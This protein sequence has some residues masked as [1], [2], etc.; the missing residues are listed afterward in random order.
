[1]RPP[2]PPPHRQVVA[3][4]SSPSLTSFS[5]IPSPRQRLLRPPPSLSG[6]TGAGP[7]Q[8]CPTPS[9]WLFPHRCQKG[10][11]GPCSAP[12][13][14]VELIASRPLMA[15]PRGVPHGAPGN[16]AAHRSRTC[17]RAVPVCPIRDVATSRAREVSLT[18]EQPSADPAAT[19]SDG[20][21]PRLV[22]SLSDIGAN[23][24]AEVGGKALNLAELLRAGS[25]SPR[26]SASPP[27]PTAGH[28]P[29]DAAPRL[30]SRG[31]P[32]RR[33]RHALPALAEARAAW[34]SPPPVPAEVA[35]GRRGRRTGA[36]ARPSRWRCARRPPRRTCRSPASPASRTPTSTWSARTRCSTRSAAAG[37]RCG[38]TARSPT[39]PPTASTT[40]G[41]ARRG[42][43]AD[44]RR[45]R[46]PA[47]CSPPNP[48]TG[49]RREA[50]I[51]AS[52]GLGE[53]VVSGAV[54][55]DHFVVDT[56]TRRDRRPPARRQAAGDPRRC[57]AAAPSTSSAADAGPACLTDEQVRDAGRARR[58]GRGALRRAAGHRVGHRRRRHAVAD[59]V[60][61]DHDAVTRCPAGAPAPGASCGSTSASASRRA[62]T[63]RSR[64]W[65]G[66]L[67]A[68]PP[69]PPSC[70]APRSPTAGPD[71]RCY[72]E[73][74]QRLFSTSP[75]CCAA[76]SGR[77]IIPGARRAWRPGP[78]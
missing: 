28:R 29:G 72:A 16:W 10:A 52:P 5:N 23:R 56:A 38:P 50:V 67:P 44:G 9:L 53:A 58:P 60:P 73:A 42:R 37:R 14:G 59:P 4:S 71:R 55:P 21:G 66:G 15:P 54:N 11:P 75:A 19:D 2:P 18:V 3:G 63:G 8:L 39:A 64:R 17:D 20:A 30:T 32:R 46:S 40:P 43:P 76:G 51:D 31:P 57:P 24:L 74:G 48:V 13:T 65:A 77:A 22:L 70:S 33:R 69:A 49:R 27:T 41:A 68:A 12:G 26:A 47:C 35:G 61:A 36:G 6:A 1:M 25:A 45:R 78:R 34:S 62:S 7:S